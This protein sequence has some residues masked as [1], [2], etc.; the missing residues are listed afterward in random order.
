MALLL[1]AG[2]EDGQ[3]GFDEAAAGL[4]LGAERKLAPDDGVTQRAFAAVVGRFQAGDFQE[5]P[6]LVEAGEQVIAQGNGRG[7]PA[8]LPLFQGL[9]DLRPTGGFDFFQRPAG[10]L[11]RVLVAGFEFGEKEGSFLC[12]A[13][14]AHE[15]AALE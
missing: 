4:T 14:S 12:G 15:A 1:A 9:I 10:G 8:P 13:S 3:Q 7:V 5:Q 11:G 2:F 6:Q